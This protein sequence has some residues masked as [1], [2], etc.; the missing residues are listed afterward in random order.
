MEV[1]TLEDVQQLLREEFSGTRVDIDRVRKILSNYK[2][3]P[4]DWAK[5]AKFDK[6]R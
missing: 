4:K 3:N 6:Y 2:T 5:Y 1:A